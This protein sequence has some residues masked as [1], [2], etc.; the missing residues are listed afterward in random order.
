MSD[1]SCKHEYSRLSIGNRL[2]YMCKHCHD[3]DT[4]R[5]SGGYLEIDWEY[6]EK[7]MKKHWEYENE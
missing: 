6:A 7:L 2:Y 1:N 3:K 4:I 5:G